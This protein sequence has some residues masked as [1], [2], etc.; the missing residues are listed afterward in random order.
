MSELILLCIPFQ[1]CDSRMDTW[2]GWFYKFSPL[3]LLM[4]LE[5]TWLLILD[6]F[7]RLD[8]VALN[9]LSLKWKVS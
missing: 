5:M 9:A 2:C 8:G 1:S 7:N 3:S 4:Y 6:I